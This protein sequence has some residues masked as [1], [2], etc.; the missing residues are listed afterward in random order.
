MKDTL[1]PGLVHSFSFQVGD[2]K[3]VPALY[4]EAAE[5][6]AMPS[7]F[8]TGFMVGLMEWACVQLLQPHCEKGEG[9][10]G[11]HI[12]VSHLAATPV[13]HW[14]RVDAQVTEIKGRRVWFDVK[15]HDGDDLIGEGR[16]Q[17]ALVAWDTFNARVAEKA[18][19]SA[20]AAH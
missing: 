5:F 8:A 11:T 10:L 6:Q 19:N 17:R 16:H 9:S 2:D 15:A 3:T 18:H 13:G 4:P 14:V 7:V 12:D 20:A 1:K